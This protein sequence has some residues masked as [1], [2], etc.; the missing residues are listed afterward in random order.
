MKIMWLMWFVAFSQVMSHDCYR[1]ICNI[2]PSHQI[3]RVVIICFQKHFNCEVSNHKK[4]FSYQYSCHI[5]YTM[6]K[7]C[8]WCDSFSL[9]IRTQVTTV[10]RI[11]ISVRFHATDICFPTPDGRRRFFLSC[12]FPF[13]CFHLTDA[14]GRCPTPTN[15][16]ALGAKTSASAEKIGRKWRSD[17]VFLGIP[18]PSCFKLF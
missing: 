14:D 2:I 3:M 6:N 4:T 16:F 12:H 15:F 17:Q 10:A 5:K 9:F 8:S 7:I 18:H 11:S 13:Y 1:N